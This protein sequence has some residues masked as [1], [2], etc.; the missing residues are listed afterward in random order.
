MMP[1]WTRS[2]L[3]A[4]VLLLGVSRT[5]ADSIYTFDDMYYISTGIMFHSVFGATTS[6]W[7]T[8]GIYQKTNTSVPT[9]VKLSDGSSGVIPGE[10]LENTTPNASEG[11]F[12]SGWGRTLSNGQQVANVSN[13]SNPSAGPIYFQYKTGVTGGSF[14]NGTATAFTFNSFD[15]KG[16]DSTA[17]L[18]FTVEGFL[19]GVL[20]DSAVLT[21]TGNTFTTYTENWQNVDMIEIVSTDANPVNWNSSTLYMDNVAINQLVRAD[22]PVPAPLPAAAWSGLALLG[23]MGLIWRV[24]RTRAA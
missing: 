13:R 14:G 6:G 15:L 17:N 2:A 8:F 20:Q 7:S 24:R 16:F 9:V 3:A 1:F 23:G 4:S 10:F 21:V 5:R 12:L 22:E 18:T 19:G 11:L